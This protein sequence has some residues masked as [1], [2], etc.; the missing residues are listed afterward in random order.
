MQLLNAQMWIYKKIY[1][2]IKSLEK[3]IQEGIHTFKK[4]LDDNKLS[5]NLSKTKMMLFG[6]RER[7]NQATD[8][9]SWRVHYQGITKCLS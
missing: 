7:N 8:T 3:L 9:A 6:N 4:W 1:K 5:L 2:I